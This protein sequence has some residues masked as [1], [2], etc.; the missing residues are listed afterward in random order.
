MKSCAYMTIFL[1]L[2]SVL[3]AEGDAAGT[4]TAP[5]GTVADE[6]A[7]V[8]PG[9][10]RFKSILDRMPFGRPP[11]GFNPDSPSGP[12][13]GRRGADATVAGAAEVAASEV[14][15]QILSSVRVSVLNVTPGGKVVVGFTDSSA[16]P[17]RNYLLEVGEKRDGCDW[18]VVDA[19]PE[20]LLVKLSKNGVEATLKLGGGS[21]PV[22]EK[23]KSGENAARG[24]VARPGPMLPG[25]GRPSPLMNAADGG[26]GGKMTGLDIARARRQ[27][28]RERQQAEEALQRQAVEQAKMEREQAAEQA[29]REREQAA[30][31]RKAQLAQLMQIQ[32]EL[33]RQREEKLVEQERRAAE[34][35]AAP[36][37]DQE[38]NED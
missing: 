37:G 29:R 35:A 31:E 19:D 4:A 16:Q 14:E 1:C 23:G 18:L 5:D 9:F 30:E 3:L 15:Q 32:E 27:E 8:D 34:E 21:G 26:E 17:A 6:E 12:G 7:V 33:R 10:E 13:D 22:E 25:R 24:A 20:K 2:S 28:R 38:T 36:G 11:P